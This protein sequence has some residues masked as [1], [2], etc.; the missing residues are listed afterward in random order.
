MKIYIEEI[1][2]A[3]KPNYFVGDRTRLATMTSVAFSSSNVMVV[4]HL[5][6]EKLL[7]LDVDYASES[8]TCLD[9][10]A[11]TFSGE[12]TITDLLDYDGKNRLL[13]SN[14]D[15][16]SGTLYSLVNNRL[17][18]LKDISLPE[19][20]GNCHGARFYDRDIICLSTNRNYMFFVE[21][22]SGQMFAQLKLPYHIKDF[23]VISEN[24]IVACFAVKSPDSEVKP[25]YASGLLNLQVDLKKS[26]FRI[27]HQWFFRPAA[28]DAICRDQESG[29]F[30]IT[31]QFGD[32]LLVVAL[33]EDKFSILGELDGFDFPHGVD[34]GQNLLAVT[35]YGDSSVDILSLDDLQLKPV[36]GISQYRRPVTSG[37]IIALC[38]NIIKK[39]LKKL[40][41]RKS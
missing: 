14:F 40:G 35:N 3:G 21:I 9:S 2:S 37:D 38:N 1:N 34:V 8:F 28:F 27:L 6:G 18:H 23:V 24:H 12:P 22:D 32:R 4:A 10:Q 15:A 19:G 30:Y 16:G 17:Q 41:L 31:D 25:T 11:T 13:T 29:R 20:S 39:L 36:S 26:D 5:V 33:Q 7:V